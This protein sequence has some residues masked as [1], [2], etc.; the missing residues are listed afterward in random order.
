[1]TKICWVP[2]MALEPVKVKTIQNSGCVAVKQS[3]DVGGFYLHID[4]LGCIY[5]NN[6]FGLLI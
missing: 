4:C 3:F 2:G 1:M 5:V 6:D